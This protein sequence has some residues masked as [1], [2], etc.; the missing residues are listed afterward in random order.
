MAH[1]FFFLF[2]LLGLWLGAELIIRGVLKLSRR[3]GLSESFV[4]LTIVAVG[5]SFPEIMVGITGAIEQNLQ[6]IDSSGIVLGNVIGSNMG[7]LGL[8]FGLIGLFGVIR[9]KRN[10]VMGYGLVLVIA[11]IL[12][13]VVA[14]DGVISQK[15]GLIF[16]LFYLVYFVFL[17]LANHRQGLTGKVKSLAKKKLIQRKRKL[18][19]Y[20]VVQLFAGLG[21]IAQASHWVVSHGVDLAAQLGVSQLAVGVILVGLGTNLPEFVVS[22][23]AAIKGK[24]ELSMS[25]LIGSNIVNILLALGSSAVIS[26]WQVSRRIVSFDLPYLLLTVIIF[27][28]F[29][30]TKQ[31][32][33][34][35]ESFLLLGLYGV[36]ISLKVLGF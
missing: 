28:L 10:Q 1:L 30:L 8:F 12:F 27:I 18:P 5:T 2:G 32:L 11:T 17:E 22:I 15:D 36:Y 16:L 7:L 33:E 21:L 31:K 24:K 35:K 26:N 14:W 19:W 13:F 23:N 25:N 6:G 34:R 20:A 29:L 3:L 4:G 9:F